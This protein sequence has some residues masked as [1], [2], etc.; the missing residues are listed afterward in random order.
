[1]WMVEK[2]SVRKRYTATA[3]RQNGKKE[4]PFRLVTLVT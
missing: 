3:K 2:E 4:D 1:M